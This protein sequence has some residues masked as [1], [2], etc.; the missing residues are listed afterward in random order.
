MLSHE[1]SRYMK[2][3]TVDRLP[4]GGNKKRTDDRADRR[5]KMLVDRDKNMTAKEIKIDL[6]ISNIGV[7]NQLIR[8]RLHELEYY[9]RI[10]RKVPLISAK[11]R[12]RRFAYSKEYRIG[13]PDYWKNVMYVDEKKF[14]LV[15]KPRK[16]YVWRR[17]NMAYE[18][19]NTQSYARSQSVMVW[20]CFG[21]NGAGD[22]VIIP[23]TM[24]GEKYRD[25]LK[26]HLKSSSK[27]IGLKRGWMLLQDN[28][29]KHNSKIVQSYLDQV[30][31]KR[32]KHPPQSPEINSIENLWDYIDRR[33]PISD[34]TSI[35]K[36][37]AAIIMEQN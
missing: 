23:S 12:K 11:N 22:I 5:I 35:G 17:K 3:R 34:R 37:S 19:G 36:F 20:A 30:K 21:A 1:S 25:L 16:R 29:P 26:E 8:N 6:A 27:K 15:M 2:H 24:T 7:S 32:I 18:P 13:H 14:Q 10:K 9:G 4:G 28:D 33:I 31:V